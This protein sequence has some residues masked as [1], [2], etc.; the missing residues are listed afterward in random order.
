MI[1][2]FHSTMHYFSK[3]RAI[4]TAYLHTCRQFGSYLHGSASSI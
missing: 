3:C 2:Q 1:P 4:C